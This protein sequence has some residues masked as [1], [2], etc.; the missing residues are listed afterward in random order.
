ML[1]QLHGALVLKG[2]NGPITET[3]HTS[4]FGYLRS[5]LHLDLHEEVSQ[6]KHQH[7]ICLCYETF[8]LVM[9]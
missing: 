5:I 6:F 2:L 3:S 8:V 9:C 7:Y 1:S 4:L